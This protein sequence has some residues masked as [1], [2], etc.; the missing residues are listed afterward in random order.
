ML[1]KVKGGE[2]TLRLLCAK[3]VHPVETWCVNSP[4]DSVIWVG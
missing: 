1:G 4:N 2:R 3:L